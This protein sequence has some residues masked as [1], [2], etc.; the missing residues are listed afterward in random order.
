MSEVTTLIT[1][2]CNV[3][4]GPR[5][6]RNRNEFCNSAIASYYMAGHIWKTKKK[7]RSGSY[8]CLK[9]R[10]AHASWNGVDVIGGI[11]QLEGLAACIK[12]KPAS[13]ENGCGA[14]DG[15]NGRKSAIKI[16]NLLLPRI[17]LCDR[18]DERLEGEVSICALSC[19]L[20]SARSGLPE[21]GVWGS[22]GCA[23][24]RN[25]VPAMRLVHR[26]LAFL[27]HI[28]PPLL[29][30]YICFWRN[31]AAGVD[32]VAHRSILEVLPIDNQSYGI[33]GLDSV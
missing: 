25:G 11:D 13:L 4:L 26:H 23:V 12:A 18:I 32:S 5:G 27:A 16:G 8:D 21:Q 30:V 29:R 3:L 7:T 33:L 22:E 17:H 2:L 10:W 19:E 14:D 31:P 24:L 20:A 15:R 9:L 6:A 1:A 28:E